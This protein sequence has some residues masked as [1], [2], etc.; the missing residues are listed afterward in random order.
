MAIPKIGMVSE[1][2]FIKYAGKIATEMTS[3]KAEFAQSK[4][5]QPR[6]ILLSFTLNFNNIFIFFLQIE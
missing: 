1:V 3:A 6:M 2:M 5:A 4:K